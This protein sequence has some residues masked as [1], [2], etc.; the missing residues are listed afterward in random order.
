MREPTARSGAEIRL[1]RIHSD[2]ESP[3]TGDD[4]RASQMET[5]RAYARVIADHPYITLGRAAVLEAAGVDV[6]HYHYDDAIHA[7]VQLAAAPFEFDPAR[8]ALDDVSSDLQSAL[9]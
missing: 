9:K 8:D 2:D 1:E 4:V 3:V 5:E 7:F 6:T